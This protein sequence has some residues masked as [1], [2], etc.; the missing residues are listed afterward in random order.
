MINKKALMKSAS[1]EVSASQI[2]LHLKSK[3]SAIHISGQSERG[4]VLFPLSAIAAGNKFLVNVI[5]NVPSLRVWA[6]F[7]IKQGV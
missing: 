7:L 6:K 1:I 5:S 3:L 2:G 4:S